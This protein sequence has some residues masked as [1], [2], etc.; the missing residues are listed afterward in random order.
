MTLDWL[1]WAAQTISIGGV[2]ALQHLYSRGEAGPSRVLHYQEEEEEARGGAS[3][4]HTYPPSPNLHARR[5]TALHE[6]AGGNLGVA[7][8]PN[9]S[10][11]KVGLLCIMVG[12]TCGPSLCW[13]GLILPLDV[14]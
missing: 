4:L 10:C 9:T 2:P 13:L 11:P 14:S 3:K 6:R 5:P 1:L 8:D 12:L 7:S